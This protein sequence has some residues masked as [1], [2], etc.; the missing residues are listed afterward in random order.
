MWLAGEE[1][2]DFGLEAIKSDR[3]GD[4]GLFA[5]GYDFDLQAIEFD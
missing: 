4:I 5:F 2:L 3:K 1:T